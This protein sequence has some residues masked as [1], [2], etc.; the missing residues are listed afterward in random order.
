MN[1]KFYSFLF[2]IC[3][4]PLDY[5]DPSAG[6]AVLSLARYPASNKTGRIGT[7]LLN[8]GGPG[9][10]GVSFVYRAGERLNKLLDGR[11][12]IVRWFRSMTQ[13]ETDKKLR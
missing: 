10:S 12:D 6:K 5:F 11:Y 9:G 1:D 2:F 3:R 8:P 7:L 4:V 13:F